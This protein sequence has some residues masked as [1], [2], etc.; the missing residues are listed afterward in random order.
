[1]SF[2]VS[3][4]KST[5]FIIAPHKSIQ[6]LH[7]A[8]G[9]SAHG[10]KFLTI[11]GDLILDSLKGTLEESLAKRWAWEPKG[12]DNGSTAGMGGALKELQPV[13]R[14]RDVLESSWTRSRRGGHEKV[15]SA[16]VARL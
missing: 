1:M 14:N 9:D 16:P 12:I 3:K 7:V 6:G 2:R 4:T 15:P 13:V 5:D 8:A 11:I 10:W